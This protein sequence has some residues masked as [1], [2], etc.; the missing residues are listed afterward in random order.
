MSETPQQPKIDGATLLDK[1]SHII[2]P[3]TLAKE[4]PDITRSDL[5]DRKNVIDTIERMFAETTIVFLEGEEGCGATTTLAQFCEQLPERTFCLFI[6]PASKITY[7]IEYLRL[8]LAEQFHFFLEGT[9]L[10]KD[11]ISQHEYNTLLFKIRRRSNKKNNIFFVVDGL[12][13]IPPEENAVAP[14]FREVLP[15]GFDDIKFIVTGEQAKF[16]KFLSGTPSKYFKQLKFSFGESSTFMSSVATDDEQIKSIHTLCDGLPGR[17][18]SVRRLLQGG[19]RFADI[20]ESDPSKFLSFLRL[21]F[22]PVENLSI[23]ERH[24]LAILTFSN[25]KLNATELLSIAKIDNVGRLDGL[26]SSCRFINY[27][28]VDD[29]MEFASDA[30]RRFSCTLLAPLRNFALGAHVNFLMSDPSSNA[31][32]A[33]LPSYYQQ[34]DQTKELI[35]LLTS[36]HFTQLLDA[37]ESLGSLRARAELGIRSAVSLRQ[38]TDVFAFSIKRSIFSSI[39]NAEGSNSQI[40]ALVALG[41][42]QTALEIAYKSVVNEERIAFLSAYA[43]QCKESTNTIDDEVLKYIRDTAKKI[44]FSALGETAIDLASEIVHVDPDL[45]M[46]IV[47]DALEGNAEKNKD[48]AFARLSIESVLNQKNK[49]QTLT[50]NITSKRI[51]DEKLQI[52][53]SSILTLVSDYSASEVIKTCE[54]IEPHRQLVFLGY[55][56]QQHKTR[57]EAI[58]VAEHGLNLMIGDAAY[59]PKMRDFGS[60]AAALPFSDNLEKVRDLIDRFDSQRGIIKDSSVSTELVRLEMTLA[61][62]EASFDQNKCSNRIINCYY[63]LSGLDDNDAKLNGFSVALNALYEIDKSESLEKQHGFKSI[64]K[65]E[66]LSLSNILP[67]IFLFPLAQFEHSLL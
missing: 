2:Y 55:W 29:T 25:R 48:E 67:T 54:V 23:E 31:A 50:S 52:F 59:N 41:D 62:A 58:N 3:Y 26:L 65:N 43:K 24:L 13:K 10:N 47:D 4:F 8:V 30:H 19:T 12:H 66:I 63:D 27:S 39:A 6:K 42:H 56:M 11:V 61:H 32:L 46:S 37:T 21:E 44:D 40:K 16:E 20:L 36:E 17:L 49:T 57:L 18:A 33:Y 60:L 7:S 14:I 22:D 38:A 28:D 15:L 64:I 45:A 1:R 51:S 9:A 34:L 5:I 53:I 35:R